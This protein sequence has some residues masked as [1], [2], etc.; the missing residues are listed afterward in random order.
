MSLDHKTVLPGYFLLQ[1]FNFTILEFDNGSAT[2]TDE[3]VVVAFVRDVVI[4]RLGTEMPRLGNPGLTEQVQSAIDR[5]QSQVGVFFGELVI[6]CFGSD[7]FLSQE[8]CKNQ[9]ALTG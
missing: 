9:F 1:P 7:M 4:L 2:G 8:R 5:S 3:V 6:H